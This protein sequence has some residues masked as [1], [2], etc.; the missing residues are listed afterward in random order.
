MG[1]DID[2]SV[3]FH[4]ATHTP[5]CK[6]FEEFHGSR[7]KC[8]YHIKSDLAEVQDGKQEE[9]GTDRYPFYRVEI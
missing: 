7:N 2:E 8:D 4:K 9:I 1:I 6:T 5:G 3:D